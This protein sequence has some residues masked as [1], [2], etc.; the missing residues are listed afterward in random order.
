MEAVTTTHGSAEPV[1]HKDHARFEY[2]NK[3]GP[4]FWY[5]QPKGQHGGKRDGSGSKEILAKMRDAIK[6][7]ARHADLASEFPKHHARYH[8]W[9]SKLIVVFGIQPRKAEYT[10]E[11]CC[12]MINMS[13][14]PF[15]D[16]R[17][18]HSAIVIGNHVVLGL[19]VH[20]LK[21]ISFQFVHDYHN[22]CVF[23]FMLMSCFY[24]VFCEFCV[25]LHAIAA[26]FVRRAHR[27]GP[28]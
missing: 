27:R 17:W 3:Q 19:R 10:L 5:G 11:E 13:P 9:C 8:S 21:R 16:T 28:L 6:A 4:V 7:G 24:V 20:L 2:K 22:L 14:I 18:K 23:I 1:C 15:G 12:E 25:R 26:I